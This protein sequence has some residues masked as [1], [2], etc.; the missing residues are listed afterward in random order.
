MVP[1]QLKPEGW[2]CWLPIT[3]HPSTRRVPTRS[4]GTLRPHP[5]FRNL[6]KK[7]P[8]SS[9]LSSST[10]LAWPCS[11]HCT[12][13]HYKLVSTDRLYCTQAGGPKVGLVA[14]CHLFSKHDIHHSSGAVLC[15]LQILSRLNQHNY[16]R[17]LKVISSLQKRKR[18]FSWEVTEPGL[19]P[20]QS[21]I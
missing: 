10:L 6:S 20:V 17:S 3:S 4:W 19:T 9:G 16:M 21:H 15:A 11:Q 2:W 1:D 12:F 14:G 8:R 18:A 7:Q 5:V 13:L